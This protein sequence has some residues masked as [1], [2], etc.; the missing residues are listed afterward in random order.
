MN[1]HLCGTDLTAAPVVNTIARHGE[2]QVSVACSTCGLVQVTELPTEAELAAYYRE[3]YRAQ[4]PWSPVRGA[5]GAMHEHGSPEYERLMDEASARMASTIAETLRLEAGDHVWE[6][7]SGDGRLLA[8]FDELKITKLGIELDAD[9]RDA[10]AA[11]GVVSYDTAPFVSPSEQPDA[12]ISVHSLEHMR[13]PLATLAMMRRHLAPGGKVWIEVPNVE[14]PY[15]DLSYF[16]QK[17]H[18]WNFSPHTLALLLNRAGFDSVNVATSKS[19]IFAYGTHGDRAPECYD[20]AA[21]RFAG[22]GGVVRGG[23][24]VAAMLA[25]YTRQRTESPG[26]LLLRWLDGK[27]PASDVGE[28]LLRGEYVR[29]AESLDRLLQGAGQVCNDLDASAQAMGESWSSNEWVR[30]FR[31]GEAA[32][33]QRCNVAISHLLN[34]AIWRATK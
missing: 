8:A 3:K 17:P 12:V 24:E 22:Y 5:D 34:Q 29:L 18:L 25:E 33:M 4:Y 28:D 1:C 2:P 15:G 9:M 13:D 14:R 32:A 23:D 6:L 31:C 26:A 21:L 7:G 27:Q 16:F 10:A 11:R 30:A 20:E 19:V